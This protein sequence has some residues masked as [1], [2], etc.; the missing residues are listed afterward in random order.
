MENGKGFLTFLGIAGIIGLIA[1]AVTRQTE[2]VHI[3]APASQWTVAE[4]GDEPVFQPAPAAPPE[5]SMTTYS[6]TEETTFP[7]GF[8]P[9]TLMPRKIVVHRVFK[10]LNRG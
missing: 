7:D 4:R 2:P 5:Q 9:D 8:D 3:I 10:V 1:Y 6:N